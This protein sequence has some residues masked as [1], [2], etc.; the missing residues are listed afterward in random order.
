MTS[1]R[2]MLEGNSSRRCTSRTRGGWTLLNCQSMSQACK[3]CMRWG[4]LLLSW[5]TTCLQGKGWGPRCLICRKRSQQDKVYT[6]RLMLRRAAWSRCRLHRACMLKYCQSP[7]AQTRSQQGRGLGQVKQQG[8]SDLRCTLCMSMTMLHR[9]SWSMWWRCKASE[10]RSA[11]GRS[12]R[13]CMCCTARLKQHHLATSMCLQ[14]KAVVEM[15]PRGRK[16]HLDKGSM[17]FVTL[18]R[19]RMRTFLGDMMCRDWWQLQGRLNMSLEGIGCMLKRLRLKSRQTMCLRGMQWVSQNRNDSSNREDKQN[20]RREMT[21]LRL[22]K[23]SQ[24]R[25]AGKRTRCPSQ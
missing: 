12:G 21:L 4:T 18:R 24:Q 10:W 6:R 5:L 20:R 16:S 13:G 9:R 22:R 2:T 8:S 1:G 7:R 14:D 25:T 23:K 17:C 11:R 15:K 19:Q 3:V